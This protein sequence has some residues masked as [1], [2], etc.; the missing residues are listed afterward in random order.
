[1][2]RL[3]FLLVFSFLLLI[4]IVSST[5]IEIVIEYEMEEGIKNVA[6][7]PT[8]PH[9]LD[10][11][12]TITVTAD[13]NVTDTDK[14]FLYYKAQSSVN[15]LS[16]QMSL[17]SGINYEGD[18]TP[19]IE[20]DWEYYVWANNTAGETYTTSTYSTH[21]EYELGSVIIIYPTSISYVSVYSGMSFII[22][23][24]ALDEGSNLQ[25]NIPEGSWSA[26][27]DSTSLTVSSVS[28]VTDHYEVDVT[29]PALATGYYNLTVTASYDSG[30]VVSNG[31]TQVDSVYYIPA[32]TWKVLPAT[33]NGKSALINTEVVL[34]TLEINNTGDVSL[35]FELIPNETWIHFDAATTF[36]VN[37]GG[38]KS[39]QVNATTPSTDGTYGYYV[40]VKCTTPEAIPSQQ[41]VGGT[42]KATLEEEPYLV[43]EIVEYPS[44]A[45][46]EQSINLKSSVTNTGSGDATNTWLNW[47]LPSGWTITEGTPNVST[48]LLQSDESLWN[49]I[50]VTTKEPRGDK[51]ITATANSTEGIVYQGGSDSKTIFIHKCGDAS[52]DE[53]YE[54]CENCPGDCGEC[55]PPSDC[56]NGVCEAGEDYINCP[57]DCPPPPQAALEFIADTIITLHQ[58]E[59]VESI[60]KLT[61]AGNVNLNEI[62]ITFLGLS[63]EWY[64]YT[65]EY[66]D[67]M[68]PGQTRS[69]IITY[70]P[71]EPGTYGYKINITSK[72]TFET[73]DATL[74][75]E[76]VEV[77][78]VCGNELCEEDFGENC[79]TC[80]QDCGICPEKKEQIERTISIILP[81]L[82]T[83]GMI[84]PGII[85]VYMLGFM[86]VKR[87]PLCGGKMQTSYKGKFITSY[88]CVKCKHVAM[89]EK[90]K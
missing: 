63:E 69:F 70:K 53:P 68:I 38:I 87:C 5:V 85:A 81:L 32:K 35:D 75:V 88:T 65:P 86:L 29:A 66:I 58:N 43:T 45:A 7:T 57:Q 83:F 21:I 80:E 89:E 22:E 71:L 12:A 78:G 3:I 20:D 2:K 19:D 6:Q 47:T 76:E 60:L 11:Y 50:T 39:V 46:A 51:D 17:V 79:T 40:L 9:L 34:G 82:V 33:F 52:C 4:P 67:K 62:R 49:N 31:N 14:V 64:S 48:S 16:N 54:T 74:I 42:L 44:S 25:T 18:F 23:T 37:S 36:S 56:G 41:E 73:V 27:I 24:T 72:E 13:V 1:M 26:Y 15:W 55:P 28:W 61:N 77:F 59:S 90:K 30:V 10:P 8:D 84:G